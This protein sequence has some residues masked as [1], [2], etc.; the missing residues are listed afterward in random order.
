[1]NITIKLLE[2][3]RCLR[4][5]MRYVKKYVEKNYLKEAVKNKEVN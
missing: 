1:M 3:E 5:S 4:H 2:F